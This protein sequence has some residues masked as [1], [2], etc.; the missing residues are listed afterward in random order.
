MAAPL[1]RGRRSLAKE[2]TATCWLC[3]HGKCLHSPGLIS[4]FSGCL[5]PS[6]SFISSHRPPAPQS[7][8]ES[9]GSRGLGR[10]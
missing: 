6:S 7:V 10:V 2:A 5:A 8:L 9:G 3:L 4:L 1:C